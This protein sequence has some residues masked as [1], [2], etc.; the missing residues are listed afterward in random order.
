[1]FTLVPLLL[2]LW[3]LGW[4][5]RPRLRAPLAGG[6]TPCDPSK[7]SIIVP[8]RNESKNLPRL[9]HS[10]RAQRIWPLELLV[11]DDHSE[12]KTAEIAEAMGAQKNLAEDITAVGVTN[13]SGVVDPDYDTEASKAITG[14]DSLTY[15]FDL[16][17]GKTAAKVTARLLYQATPPFYLQD[18]FCTGQQTTDMNRLL[19][20]ADNLVSDKTPE[21]KDWVLQVGSVAE[22]S[23]G[24]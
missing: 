19:Y 13:T 4:W 5:L 20:L 10:I 12:D 21:I 3:S 1:M 14:A 7:V 6:S 23:S 22:Y 8:A 18:R 2:V 15:A 17:D 11:V 24:Q 16:P 9:I